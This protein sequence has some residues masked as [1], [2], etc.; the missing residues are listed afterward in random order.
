VPITDTIVALSTPPGRSGIAVIRLSGQR[1]LEIAR[2]LV[3][4]QD[5]TPQSHR[6]VLKNLHDPCTGE[7]LDR[8][9]L[10]YFKSPHSFTGEDVV[11]LSCHG[12]PVIL[13]SLIDAI[14]NLDARLAGPG[15]FTLRALSHG[16]LNLSQAEAI[17]DLINAQ[18]KAAA[19]QATR[20]LRVNS[21]ANYQRVF[22][23]LKTPC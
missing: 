10:T 15:E 22:N 9:L 11:E 17:R 6:V 1:S 21:V 3:R 23:R 7:V 13:R 16:R 20:Q 5:F 14:L 4:D 19:Q 2:S 12:S 18:T 8:A